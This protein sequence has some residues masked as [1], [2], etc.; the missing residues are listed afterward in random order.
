M[1]KSLT[2]L[3]TILLTLGQSIE[4]TVQQIGTKSYA[5]C[6]A[7]CESIR[8]LT[9][10]NNEYCEFNKSLWQY[11]IDEEYQWEQLNDVYNLSD[12]VLKHE[13]MVGQVESM[14][15]TIMK[16]APALAG[17]ILGLFVLVYLALFRVLREDKG[18][19][20]MIAIADPIKEGAKVFLREEYMYLFLF[21]VL[22]YIIIGGITTQ[23][24]ET[25]FSF[26]FGAG[27]S[28]FCGYCGMLIAVEAN[29]RTVNGAKT[30]IY[31]YAFTIAFGSGGVMG[32]SV[33]CLGLLG[34]ITIYVIIG[35]NTQTG[36]AYMA[37]F[38]FG[39]SSVALFARVGGGIYAKAADVGADLMGA[40]EAS[41]PEDCP[42]NP[43]TIADNIGDNVGD[44]AGMGADLFE[45]FV[46]SII[47][48]IQLSEAA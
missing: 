8:N 38:G 33:V 2:L 35:G 21:V 30:D 10:D 15:A 19:D 6:K 14:N 25:G 48:A 46:G 47:A 3:A 39:A 34:L 37:G 4:I 23:W 5:E 36:T 7:A 24:I 44:V 45:S 22:M 26:V 31:N 1:D 18:S 43:A 41:I 11:P 9:E 32:L 27:L 28:A 16:I 29:V 17:S 13:E 20:T 12:S 40:I 42:R